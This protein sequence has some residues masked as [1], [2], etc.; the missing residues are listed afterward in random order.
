[1]VSQDLILPQTLCTSD[2]APINTNR[3][4][5]EILLSRL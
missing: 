3:K 2:I 4:K 5:N 1:M